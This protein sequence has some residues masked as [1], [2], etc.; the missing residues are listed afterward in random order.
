MEIQWATLHLHHSLLDEA[1]EEA[2]LTRAVGFCYSSQKTNYKAHK[3]SATGYQGI[4]S[5]RQ[6]DSRTSTVLTAVFSTRTQ[7]C[8]H[9]NMGNSH[10]LPQPWNTES[11]GH[12]VLAS[13]WQ[14]VSLWSVSACSQWHFVLVCLRNIQNWSVLLNLVKWHHICVSCIITNERFWHHFSTQNRF[15]FNQWKSW[16]SFSTA[17]RE[18]ADRLSPV[19]LSTLSEK[20]RR[21]NLGLDVN[22]VFYF[23]R[24]KWIQS[25]SRHVKL[26]FC[27]NQ[28]V[29]QHLFSNQPSQLPAV[30]TELLEDCSVNLRN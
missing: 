26:C 25:S 3:N 9:V 12:A 29:K 27:K 23:F 11:S 19:R 13:S 21:L 15:I 22:T 30:L 17:S 10:P 5:Q 1:C 7:I 28:T 16:K 20:Y 18:C 2:K 8:M 24:C 14:H 6:Q 4:N